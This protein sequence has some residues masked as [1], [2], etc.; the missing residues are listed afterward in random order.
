MV[1]LL[2]QYPTFA[3]HAQNLCSHTLI[4]SKRW[5]SHLN[6]TV[7]L[8]STLFHITALSIFMPHSMC[9]IWTEWC[10]NVS[11]KKEEDFR[12]NQ[13]SKYPAT[14]SQTQKNFDLTSKWDRSHLIF[15]LKIHSLEFY[16]TFLL[17]SALH[18]CKLIVRGQIRKV[19]S[20][21]SSRELF[22]SDLGPFNALHYPSIRPSVTLF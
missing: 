10:K 1:S 7:Y 22:L 13:N 5:I 20:I 19:P 14:L 21:Y 12:I 2:M 18:M 9:R 16:K 17:T 15:C 3:S 8:L 6:F 4:S 11:Q